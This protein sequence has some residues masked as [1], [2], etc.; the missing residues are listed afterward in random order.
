MR[1]ALPSALAMLL[2]GAAPAPAQDEAAIPYGADY[3]PC[4]EQATQGIVECVAARTGEW[5][6]R[7]NAAYKQAMERLESDARRTLLRDAQRL[8]IGYRDANCNF[9]ANAEGSLSR[10][11]AAECLRATTASRALELERIANPEG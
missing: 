10:I 11:E 2:L 8:W 1:H 9:Y 4:A 7:L 5:D 3:R 6:R